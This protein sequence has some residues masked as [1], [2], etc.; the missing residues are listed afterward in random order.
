MKRLNTY[1]CIL[2]STSCVHVSK[3][4]QFQQQTEYYKNVLGVQRKTI[5]VNRDIEEKYKD[6]CAWVERDAY[7]DSVFIGVNL[8]NPLCIKRQAE[9]LAQHE[10]C[11][12]YL[13]HVS[14]PL[15][16]LLTDKQKEDAIKPCL[17]LI[18]KLKRSK[19]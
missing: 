15:E 5:L 16:Q 14:W 13:G 18:E 17:K 4:D 6:Y 9:E 3:L 19:N 10:V 7:S 12:I 8:L 11:H 1:F 2:V